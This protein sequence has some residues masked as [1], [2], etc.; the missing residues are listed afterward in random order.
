MR[1]SCVLSL[2]WGRVEGAN[3]GMIAFYTGFA[4]N[5]GIALYFS[6]PA[7]VTLG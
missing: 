6:L 3:V 5:I 2:R 4:W 7:W 1:R